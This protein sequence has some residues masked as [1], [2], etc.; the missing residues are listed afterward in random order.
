VIHCLC[1]SPLGWGVWVSGRAG[2]GFFCACV[3]WVW[4]FPVLDCTA[5]SLSVSLLLSYFSPFW[6]VVS[7]VYH[8][9]SDA[10]WGVGKENSTV[11]GIAGVGAVLSRSFHW[12]VV[13]LGG[14]SPVSVWGVRSLCV[15]LGGP[16]VVVVGVGAL[17]YPLGLLKFHGGSGLSGAEIFHWGWCSG[18]IIPWDPLSGINPLFCSGSRLWC[19][20]GV[21][22]TAWLVGEI[23]HLDPLGGLRDSTAVWYGGVPGG[24]HGVCVLVCAG[25]FRGVGSGFLCWGRR[26]HTVVG[27]CL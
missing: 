7:A 20:L 21:E 6:G 22:S 18:C 15:W 23:I 8:L 5:G 10:L 26:D 13:C 1:R 25:C 4:W 9:G 16:C 24:G 3:L 17:L 27:G 19:F 14:I 12:L 11:A 2:W